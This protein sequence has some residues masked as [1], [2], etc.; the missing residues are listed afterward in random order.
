MYELYYT[1]EF[2]RDVKRLDG[3]MQIKLKKAVEKIMEN[4][5]RFK[6]LEHVDGYRVR[7]DVYRILYRVSGNRIEF[8]RLGKRDEVYD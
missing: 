4:P 6:H 8:I 1:D 2:K 7:F 5:T 3:S